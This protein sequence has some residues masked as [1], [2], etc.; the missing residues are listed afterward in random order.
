MLEL[1]IEAWRYGSYGQSWKTDPVNARGVV[2]NL[3]SW[4]LRAGYTRMMVWILELVLNHDALDARS[5][6]ENLLLCHLDQPH[7]LYLLGA[8]NNSYPSF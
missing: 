2:K 8:S 5:C 6:V 7:T 1:R 3:T 4:M